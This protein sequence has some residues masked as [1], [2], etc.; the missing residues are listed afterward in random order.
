MLSSS[1]CSGAQHFNTASLLQGNASALKCSAQHLHPL[2][3]I[4]NLTINYF[5]SYCWLNPYHILY[6]SSVSYLQ[7]F[8]SYFKNPNSN[9]DFQQTF[10]S[11]DTI[12]LTWLIIFFFTFNPKVI[13]LY[14][15]FSLL[16]NVH[17][18]FYLFYFTFY[19]I[20]MTFV[21][22]LSLSLS[23]WYLQFG[24]QTL[25]PNFFYRYLMCVTCN[26]IFL[27]L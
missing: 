18:T 2:V 25:N 8:I 23:N 19:L 12:V 15:I 3:F 17:F 22:N 7:L 5:I 16:L 13:T 21:S 27:Y 20:I 6:L 11:S 10:L 9:F 4:Y 14:L 26:L 24:I 1:S